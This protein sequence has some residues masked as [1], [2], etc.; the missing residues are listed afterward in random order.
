M[1]A[2]GKRPSNNDIFL[3]KPSENNNEDLFEGTFARGS[4]IDDLYDEN[5]NDATIETV[6]KP[7]RRV[8]ID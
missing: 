5:R 3:L 2:T 8:R 6:G 7:I 1:Y 4:A